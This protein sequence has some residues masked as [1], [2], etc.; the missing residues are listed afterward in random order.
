[1][2]NF[3]SV[4]VRFRVE[5]C[6]GGE[7]WVSPV[8]LTRTAKRVGFVRSVTSK[9]LRSPMRYLVVKLGIEITEVDLMEL[10]TYREA[11]LALLRTTPLRLVSW[12]RLDIVAELR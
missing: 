12:K 10:N 6:L 5:Q 11:L 1:M 9:F 2:L 4:A 3:D 8:G 7:A